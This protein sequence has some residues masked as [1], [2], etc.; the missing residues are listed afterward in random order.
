MWTVVPYIDN[1]SLLNK[2]LEMELVSLT[3]DL[4]KLIYKKLGKYMLLNASN[5]V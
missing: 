2:L 3:E 4:F 5:E 1:G